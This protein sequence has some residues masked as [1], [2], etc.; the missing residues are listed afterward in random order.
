MRHKLSGTVLNSIPPSLSEYVRGWHSI[1]LP[2][3]LPVFAL[4]FALAQYVTVVLP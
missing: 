4:F 3:H 1:C 2:S